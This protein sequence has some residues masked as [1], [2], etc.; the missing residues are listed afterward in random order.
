V[1]I[2][3]GS[4]GCRGIG[5]LE[6]FSKVISKI[7]YFWMKQGIDVDDSIHGFRAER[8]TI[9]ANIEAKLQIQLS[10]VRHQTLYQV[11]IDLVN[12]YDTMD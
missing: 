11:F 9:T 5:L 2:P 3:K 10:C 4:G 6:I 7:M 8:G 1:L 12:A